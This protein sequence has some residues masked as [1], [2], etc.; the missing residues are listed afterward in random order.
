VRDEQAFG[1]ALN[2]A[3]PHEKY[4][5]AAQIVG[6]F[7]AIY[8]TVFQMNTEYSYE[9]NINVDVAISQDD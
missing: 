6:R 1:D 8:L 4:S 3:A 7:A 9:M 5:R 2:F